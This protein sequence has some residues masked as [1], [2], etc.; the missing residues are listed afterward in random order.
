M[1]TYVLTCL[2]ESESSAR[3]LCSLIEKVDPTPIGVGFFELDER[4]SIWEIEA[5]FKEKPKIGII[6]LLE[7]LY[8]TNFSLSTLEN[9]ITYLLTK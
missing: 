9:V 6:A 7:G 4:N 1:K 2:V 8:E 5:Y 3:Q